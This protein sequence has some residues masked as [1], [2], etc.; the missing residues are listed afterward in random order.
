MNYHRLILLLALNLIPLIGV[1]LWQW[2]IFIV[3]WLFWL[4]NAVIGAFN[5]LKI[6]ASKGGDQLSVTPK[7][8]RSNIGLA[9][10]FV[11]H[12]GFFTSAHAMIIL[13]IFS[14]SFDGEPWDIW[15]WTWSWLQS[16]DGTLWL[17]VLAMVAY[18]LFDTIQFYLH[19][20]SNKQPSKQMVEPY[21]RIIIAHVV[22]LLGA[23]FVVKFGFELAVIILLVLIKMLVNFTDMVKKQT[24]TDN[25]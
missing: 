9:V 8:W 20:S 17:A 2:D 15:H 12:Y 1:I 16:I 3:I 24:A 23:I 4:E 18:W 19:E 25:I 21:S 14:K 5:C 22:L 11:F 10:F 7:S 6:L 13:E